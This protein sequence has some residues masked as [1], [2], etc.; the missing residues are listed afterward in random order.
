M[1][2]KIVLKD[3]LEGLQRVLAT[4]NIELA[5]QLIECMKDEIDLEMEEFEK[6]LEDQFD[7][8]PV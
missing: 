5:T 2:E 7:N 1:V 6:D 4:G 3:R 8:M